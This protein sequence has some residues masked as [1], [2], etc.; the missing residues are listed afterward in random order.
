MQDARAQLTVVDPANLA[1]NIVTA[2]HSIQTVLNQITQLSHEVQ[3]LA[4]QEQNLQNMPSSISSNILGQYT[5][6]F[7]NL[8]PRCKT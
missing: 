7:G 1:Q 6:Q 2:L 3:S 5:L 4:Y 8:W